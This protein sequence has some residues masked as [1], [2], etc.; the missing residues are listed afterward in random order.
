MKT[1]YA[2][3]S[4]FNYISISHTYPKTTVFTVALA[5]TPDMSEWGWKGISA[6]LQ[7]LG[8]QMLNLECMERY[9]NCGKNDAV[10][11]DGIYS[12]RSRRSCSSNCTKEYR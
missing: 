5:V 12:T 2:Y 3:I 6:T 4:S 7:P 10:K 11:I 8:I 1:E 9:L